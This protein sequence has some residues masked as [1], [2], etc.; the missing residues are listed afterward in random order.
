VKYLGED[1]E[2]V[3][4]AGAV[5][6]CSPWDLLIGDRFICRR[7][8]QKLY[9]RALTIGLQGYAK[10]HEPRYSRL[11]NWEGIKKSRSVR[12]FDNFAKCLVGKFE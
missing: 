6:I 12:D 5:A 4:L 2:K 9:D 10:L 7:L 8:V 3:P 1:R 11:A